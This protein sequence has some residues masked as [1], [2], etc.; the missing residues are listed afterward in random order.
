M[1]YNLA[2]YP[3]RRFAED[4]VRFYAVQLILSLEHCH[5]SC[6]LHRDIKPENILLTK[7][8]YIK[9]ISDDIHKISLYFI[10]SGCS[11]RISVSLDVCLVQT[12]NVTLAV[13]HMVTCMSF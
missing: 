3:D 13:A 6:I 10:S 7:S 11:L 1:R 5:K 4:S 12:W 9:V 2:Q 8:G